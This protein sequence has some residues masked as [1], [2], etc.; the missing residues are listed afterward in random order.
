MIERQISHNTSDEEIRAH[1]TYLARL[2][3]NDSQGHGGDEG[4]SPIAMPQPQRNS[5]SS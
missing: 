2:G 5:S 3:R 4:Y 1:S